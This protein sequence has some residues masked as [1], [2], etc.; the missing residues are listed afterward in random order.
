MDAGFKADAGLPTGGSRS[1]SG[2]AAIACATNGTKLI[3][4]HYVVQKLYEVTGGDAFV[5]SDVGQ[6]QMFAAQYYKFDQPRR[7]INSG[8]LG[9]MGVGLPY[10]MGVLSP[11]RGRRWPASPAG[12]DPDVHPGIVHLQAVQ[13][14]HQ[15]HQ[16]EQRLPRHG[17]PVAGDVLFQPLFP[18]LRPFAARFRQAGRVLWPVGMK[19]ERP[20]DVEPALR[21]AFTEHKNDLVFMDFIV[22]PTANVFRWSPPAGL[23][24]M[25]LAEDL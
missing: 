25:I 17:A 16:L 12:V 4:P 10:G 9:T 19:I 15:D 11:T 21:K 23:T 5:T 20:E 3:M 24:D 18:I 2:G 13:V 14:A 22:D 7:W 8:G 6:H 1:R